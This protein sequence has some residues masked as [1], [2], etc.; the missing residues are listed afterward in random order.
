M[1]TAKKSKKD[2]KW[3]RNA[4]YCL[5][6]KNSNRR[7]KNKLRRLA[8]HLKRFPGDKIAQNAVKLAQAAIRGYA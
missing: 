8:K 7:E 6:Y 1:A 3:G 4:A 5:S 2:R